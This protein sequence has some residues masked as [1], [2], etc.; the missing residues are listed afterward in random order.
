MHSVLAQ[1]QISSYSFLLIDIHICF[2]S[3]LFCFHKQFFVLSDVI[4]A[5]TSVLSDTD[6]SISDV[7]N[8]LIS[9]DPVKVMG[10]D[11]IGPSMLKHCV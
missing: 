8:I 9:L 6:T 4:T 1:A 10:I 7:Y 3:D 2:I 11:G 5:P